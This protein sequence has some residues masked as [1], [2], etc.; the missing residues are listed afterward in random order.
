MR[1][2]RQKRKISVNRVDFKKKTKYI[3]HRR[4]RNKCLILMQVSV[5]TGPS[6]SL[7]NVSKSLRLLSI[8]YIMR[9][10]K[11]NRLLI[12]ETAF[13]LSL[14]N[15]GGDATFSPPARNI[16]IGVGRRSAGDTLRF[17]SLNSSKYR[18][19]AEVL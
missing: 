3:L 11:G 17:A 16:R 10:T 18:F 7:L 15:V 19:R 4:P 13:K 6:H 1:V 2:W 5:V 14:G 12:F 9:R 8:Q